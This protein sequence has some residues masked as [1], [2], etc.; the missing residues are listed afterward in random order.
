MGYSVKQN[1]KG[2]KYKEQN[3]EWRDFPKDVIKLSSSEKTTWV[4]EQYL[5]R[6]KESEEKAEETRLK[7]I[8]LSEESL[9]KRRAHKPVK[10]A[11]TKKGHYKS[12][13]PSTPDINE[14][15]EG[16]K[17]PEKKNVRRKKKKN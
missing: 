5:K 6:I 15:W 8:Q 4:R 7:N 13:D 11:R 9:A 12:D 17:A 3:G 16:G 14:A 1:E 2:T 10:R